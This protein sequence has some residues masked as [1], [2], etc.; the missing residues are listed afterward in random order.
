VKQKEL[1]IFTILVLLSVFTVI[2]IITTGLKERTQ[3]TNNDICYTQ[4]TDSIISK[5][6]N[7]KED[8]HK[9][10][11][12]N[13]NCLACHQGIEPVRDYNSKMMQDIFARG[14]QLGDP[15]GCII[16]H[17][18]NPNETK[19]QEKA[20][21]GSP[22]GNI[23]TDF[24]PVPSALQVN[25][26]TCGLCHED[27]TYNVKRSIM[28]TDAG[29][30]KAILWSWG[31][32]TENHEHIY[33]D[34]AVNDP[35]GSVPRFG[36]EVYKKYM[37][38]MAKNHPGQFPS[39]LFKIPETDMSKLKENPEQAAYAYLRSC[40]ACHLSNKGK[41]DRGHFRGMG[42]AACHSLYSNEGYYE[43]NDK[44]IDKTKPGHVLTH[45]FQGTRKS[46]IKINKKEF[47][48]IQNSTCAACHSAGRRIGHAY[49][50]LMAFDH[51]TPFNDDG[52]LQQANSG[53]IFKYIRDDAHHKIDVN[54]K[55]VAGLSCQDCHTTNS[56][57]G[58]GN[59]GATTLA[60]IEIECADCHGTPQKFPWQLPIGYG[61][62]FG[63]TLNNKEERGLADKPMKV[64]SDFATV[65]PKQDGYLLSARGNALGNVVKKGNKV[66]VHSA[67]GND[68]DVPVLKQMNKDNSWTNKKKAHTAMVRVSKHMEK[69]ECYSCHSTWAPQYYGYQYNMDFT[70][71]SIDWINS[72]EKV[73]KDG[74][75]ADYNKDYLMLKG[76]STGDYSHLRWENPP[77]GINGEGRVTPLVGCIQTVSTVIG[78]DGKILQL[79]NVA[80]LKNGVNAM[81][82]APL[83]PHTTSKASREC[84]DCHGNDQAMGYGT[85][86]GVYNSE[87]E[88]ER[89]ADVITADGDIVSKHSKVQISAIKDLHGDF[90][91]ILNKNGKQLMTVGSH[92]EASMPLTAEQRTKL[93]RKQTCMACHQDIPDGAIPMKMLGQV[94]KIA[95]LSFASDDAH[96]HLLNENNLIVSWIK[97]IAICLGLLL[98]P[99]IV[100]YICKRKKINKMLKKLLNFLASKL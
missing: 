74:T 72:P 41:Q 98:I 69:L 15:N 18:G 48:G 4:L 12:E 1:R 32:G 30:I 51:K 99:L 35:D 53:Y 73:E 71:E 20:H 29:K 25:D 23:I 27:H 85:D 17:G 36:S 84:T 43:G 33:G 81:E 2:Y 75:T 92:W 10:P 80:K 50:G 5:P 89:F 76:S 54:G 63:K 64:S 14:T 79:N 3:L 16:C 58:N 56:M 78:P 19:N 67:T 42:C 26:K 38:E 70:K 86:G 95:N 77:L 100:L 47:S 96:A 83:N 55:T 60:S 31:I 88:I 7:T 93:G 28:N 44:S 65:Y 34:H 49:Q 97:A 91:Q 82:M 62:E 59:I 45:S 52:S 40:N 46:K 8:I 61:D 37:S 90:M 24:T 94:A 66:I 13:N 6:I 22:K 11:D 68:F 87:P 57:H 39:E 9:Y 21:S